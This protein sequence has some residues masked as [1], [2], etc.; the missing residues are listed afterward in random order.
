MAIG[1]YIFPTQSLGTKAA[2]HPGAN[3]MGMATSP[4]A[5][6]PS[7]GAQAS[8][9]MG[10]ARLVNQYGEM[11]DE[12]EPG[13]VNEFQSQTPGAPSAP[14]RIDQTSFQEQGQMSDPFSLLEQN[15][16]RKFGV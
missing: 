16:N 7:Q 5:V 13:Q 14:G 3:M 2:M 1:D 8:P 6:N 4:F 15:I 11:Q 9:F 12:Q 10:L